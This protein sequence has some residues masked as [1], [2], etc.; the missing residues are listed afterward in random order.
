[1]R[2]DHMASTLLRCHFGT[3]CQRGGVSKT[4]ISHQPA[5]FYAQYLIVF[6]VVYELSFYMFNF[7]YFSQNVFIYGKSSYRPEINR[8]SLERIITPRAMRN[9][10]LFEVNYF[11]NE[12]HI[13]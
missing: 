1:M 10:D 5:S 8:F 12:V 4:M 11:E 3:K 13:L 6:I 9:L 2:R 7:F